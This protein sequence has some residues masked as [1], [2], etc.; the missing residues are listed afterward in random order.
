MNCK[1]CGSLLMEND[2]FC[3]VCGA[4]AEGGVTGDFTNVGQAQSNN[5][6]G[7]GSFVPNEATSSMENNFMNQPTS[8]S[9]D[10]GVN[11][12]NNGGTQEQSPLGGNSSFH[13]NPSFNGGFVQNNVSGGIPNYNNQQQG[14]MNGNYQQTPIQP[15]KNNTTK[16]IIIGVVIAIIVFIGVIAVGFL[17]QNSNKGK[18]EPGDIAMKDTYTVN[19]K[20][21]TFKVPTNLIYETGASS[22]MLGDEDS[23][24]A[25]QLE[26]VSG[27]YNQFLN[28]K[29]KMQ[30]ILQKQGITAS[31]AEEK[32]I[33]GMKYITIE[34]SQSGQ[35]V[36]MGIAKANSMFVFGVTALNQDNEFDYD[37]LKTMASI[38]KSA[39]YK[40]ESNNIKGFEDFDFGALEEIGE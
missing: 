2:R 14:W 38:L 33:G 16:F 1:K 18:S 40:G 31:S 11:L 35:N 28:N 29:S 26:I 19:F 22:M 5:Q 15:Q 30:G 6:G 9:F 27:S 37:I 24:W 8:T 7:F 23:T 36:L 10:T 21:F 25:A 39:E 32:T 3:K 17:S 13:S 34:M 4:P 12:N 20:G